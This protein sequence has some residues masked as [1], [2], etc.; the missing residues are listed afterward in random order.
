MSLGRVLIVTPAYN[1]ERSVGDVVRSVTAA[2]FDICVVDDGSVDRTS[3]VAREAGAIV[4]TLPLNLGVGGALR[5]GFRYA[6]TSGYEVAVQVDADGQHEPAQIRALLA[7][8]DAADADLV[9]G[10]RFAPDE[11]DREIYPVSRGRRI[12]M[13]MLAWQAGR[14]S[15][16]TITD[17][18]SGFRAVREPLLSRFAREYPVEYLGDTVEALID[19]GSAGARV[20]EVPVT[21]SLRAHGTSTAGTGASLWYV[22]RVIVANEL[23]RNRAR[24]PTSLGPTGGDRT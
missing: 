13:R 24:R 7:A 22:L 16:T 4:L 17:A 18:T 2:G 21:M 23:Q 20:V 1:E 19:A 8:L 6:V 14:S 3:E 11:T 12:A 5:C 15:H 10:S 9:I